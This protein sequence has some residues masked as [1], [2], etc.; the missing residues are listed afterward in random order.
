MKSAGNEGVVQSRL[1]M[2]HIHVLIIFG[3][4]PTRKLAAWTRRK[5]RET[6]WAKEEC[7]KFAEV[8]LDKSLF[9]K[10]ASP[11]HFHSGP[12]FNGP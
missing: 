1:Q 3:K 10:V 12:G 5:N 9:F 2:L 8:K 7:L 6:F 4:I 11:S